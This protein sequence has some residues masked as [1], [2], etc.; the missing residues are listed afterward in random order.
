MIT[1]KE[2]T[3]SFNQYLHGEGDEEIH[4]FISGFE[5]A[6]N[7]ICF[8]K[9]KPETMKEFLQKLGELV[10]VEIEAKVARPQ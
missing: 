6:Y 5:P 2:Q 8:V 1:V 10:G 4:F 3:M 9:G 7:P